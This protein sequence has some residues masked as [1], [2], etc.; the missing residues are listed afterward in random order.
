M[1]LWGEVIVDVDEILHHGR[2]AVEKP[3]TRSADAGVP[4]QPHDLIAS[5]EPRS[6]VTLRHFCARRLH[7]APDVATGPGGAAGSSVEPPSRKAVGFRD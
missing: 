6:A 7:E 4:Q 1:Q 5:H 2:S 3:P